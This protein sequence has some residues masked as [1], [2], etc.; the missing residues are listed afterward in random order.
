MLARVNQTEDKAKEQL[1]NE[2]AD[3]RQR[4]A[5]LEAKKAGHDILDLEHTKLKAIL[6]AMSDYIYIIDQFCNIKYVNPAV[7]KE[8]GPPGSLK[9]FKYFHGLS[10]E[11]P[12][13]NNREIFA[14][15][16]VRQE[17]YISSTGKTYDVI[18]TPLRNQ[19]GSVDKLA[20]LR[21]FTERKHA[22][23]EMKQLAD[24]LSRSNTDLQQFAYAASHDLQ[25]PLRVIAGFVKLLEKGYKGRLDEKADEFIK[26]AL[27]GVGRMQVLINDLLE[28]SKVGTKGL[29]MRPTDCFFV[30]DKAVCDLWAAIEE[31]GASVTCD[32]LPTVMA[33]VSQMS[34]LFQNLISNAIKFR[35]IE[36][37]RVHISSRKEEGEWVFSVRD[38]GI[39]IDP[40][41]AERIFVMFKR[42]HTKEEYPGTGIG[43]AICKRIVERHGGR[44]W[45]ESGQGRGSTFY[46]TIPDR[47]T[48]RYVPERRREHRVK[49]EVFF[50]FDFQGQRFAA[51][52]IDS[53]E[54]GLCIKISG[55]V[56]VKAGDPL[57]FAMGHLR[58][59]ANAVWLK[60]LPDKTFIGLQKFH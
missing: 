39:G 52:T 12:W 37:V 30:V 11:C 16:T 14:G 60:R 58:V 18:N 8:L 15:K 7:E 29:S 3:L 28:Y 23:E 24:E 53:C 54:E 56:P 19:D 44:I 46:F 36:P 20:I 45:V 43:L 1:A 25:E 5:D 51:G 10:G 59:K 2:I 22:E 42:L 31:S 33:D 40:G 49:Q 17:R 48:A 41:Q 4:V 50:D 47:D 13:C 55:A 26:Y 57:D 21:D 34:R 35:G 32:E 6:D 38:N 27:G 9:C